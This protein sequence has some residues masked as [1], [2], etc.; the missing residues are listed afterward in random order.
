[1][2]TRYTKILGYTIIYN[3]L[4]TSSRGRLPKY[5]LHILGIHI[6]DILAILGM[7]LHVVV[8]VY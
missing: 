7:L 6:L 4:S 5:M 1:M 8:L 3:I 2:Y